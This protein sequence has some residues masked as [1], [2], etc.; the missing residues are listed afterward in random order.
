M[1]R[2]YF[3]LNITKKKK[4]DQKKIKIFVN[5]FKPKKKLSYKDF[6]SMWVQK[7]ETTTYQ[8]R[9]EFFE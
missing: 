8:N 1:N 2:K 3:K 4:Y 6:D 9:F 7:T 5:F